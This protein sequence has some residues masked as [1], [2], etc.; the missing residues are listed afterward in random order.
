[1]C[2]Q[3]ELEHFEHVY[4][5]LKLRQFRIYVMPRMKG[6]SANHANL[7]PLHPAE[8]YNPDAQVIA[9]A[10]YALCVVYYGPAPLRE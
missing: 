1:M 9:A 6:A 7:N 4:K 5:C 10:L 8:C 3:V 2:L